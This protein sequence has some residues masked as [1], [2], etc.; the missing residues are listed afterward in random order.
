MSQAKEEGLIVLTALIPNGNTSPNTN[1]QC[2]EKQPACGRCVRLGLKC[3]GSGQQRF[4]FQAEKRY[5]T[6]QRRNHALIPLTGSTESGSSPETSGMRVWSPLLDRPA[7][8]PPSSE[9]SL[10]A[11]AFTNTIKRSTDFGYNM[12]WAFGGFLEDVPRRLG[13][14]EALDRAVDAITTAHA[15]FCAGRAVTVEAL[16]KYCRALGTLREYLGHPVHAL[17]SSTLGAVMI[18][19]CCQALLGCSKHGGSGHAEGAVQILRARRGFGPRDDFERSLFLSLRGVIV[20]PSVRFRYYYVSRDTI[21]TLIT[22]PL[23]AI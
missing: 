17:S 19:L 11:N 20:S 8:S 21:L 10:L 18:L 3:I 13:T 5:A 9:L 2:D 14:N 22:T 6:I 16:N 4:K 23:L 15:G 12:W 1:Y 7:A